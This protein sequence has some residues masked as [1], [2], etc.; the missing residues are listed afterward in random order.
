MSSPVEDCCF[1]GLAYR[2]L[3]HSSSTP[4]RSSGFPRIFSINCDIV[5]G[6]IPARRSDFGIFG[7]GAAAV[8]GC[9]LRSM[10]R[11][12]LL[13][14]IAPNGGT[15]GTGTLTATAVAFG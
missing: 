8:S 13:E 7:A 10:G 4:A 9:T 14:R 12:Q 11:E 5:A 3:A 1:I 15:R 2:A 6:P